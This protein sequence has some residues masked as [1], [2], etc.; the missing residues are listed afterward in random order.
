MTYAI[1]TAKNYTDQVA[2]TTLNQANNYTDYKFGQ[3]NQ[4]I[5]KVRDEARQ[6]AAIGLAAASLRYDDRPGKASVA[7]GG[8]VWRGQGAFALGAGYTSEDGRVRANL[9]AT[10]A[11]GEWGAGAGVSFTLN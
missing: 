3:L 8:G 10:T 9:S 11:G 4:E 6:A 5:G 2:V 1:D 7:V